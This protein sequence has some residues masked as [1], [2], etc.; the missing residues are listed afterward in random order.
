[1]SNDRTRQIQLLVEKVY[2]LTDSQMGWIEA[3]VNQF[4]LEHSYEIINSNLIDN[5]MLNSFGDALLIHHCMS[6]ESFSKDKFEY[7]LERVANFCGSDAQ[8]AKRGNPGH[9]ITINGERFSLKTQADSKIRENKIHISKFMELGQG[10]WGNDPED[11]LELREQF[12]RHMEAYERILSLRTLSKSPASWIYELVEI[13][14]D[15]LLEA[16]TGELRMT[17][18]SKQFPKPGYCYIR[19]NLGEEK[20][21]IYF[22]GGSERKLQIKH[23]LKRYCRVHARWQFPPVDLYAQL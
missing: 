6:K 9:D 20:F 22:D 1:M 2:G 23:L 10:Q 17:T 14:K 11:L 18:R 3:I 13:P 15:L 16:R 5:C 12:F 7:I 21:R 8:L 4:S 19:D